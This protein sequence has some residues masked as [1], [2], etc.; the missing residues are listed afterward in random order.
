M[1]ENCIIEVQ[2]LHL[3]TKTNWSRRSLLMKC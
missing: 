1:A 3:H 2:D